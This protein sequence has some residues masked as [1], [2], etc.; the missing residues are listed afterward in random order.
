MA[1]S[2]G[3]DTRNQAFFREVNERITDAGTDLFSETET[4]E[5]L[6]ECGRLECTER[7]TMTY[8]EYREVRGSPHRFI[9]VSG[10]DDP[11]LERVVERRDEYWIVETFERARV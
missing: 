6:C 4:R 10:H 2:R 9:V 3:Q 11:A 1:R 7:F 5:L 8:A